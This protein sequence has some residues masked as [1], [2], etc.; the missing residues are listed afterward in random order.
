MPDGLAHG[1]PFLIDLGESFDAVSKQLFNSRLIGQHLSVAL[2]MWLAQI[3]MIS[4][5]SIFPGR[6]SARK[7]QA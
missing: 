1:G 5:Q 4:L 7:N 2:N 3:P 6:C